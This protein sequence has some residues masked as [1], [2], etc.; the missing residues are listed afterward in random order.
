MKF[1]HTNIENIQI[2]KV[3][4]DI[5][6]IHQVNT[7]SRFS[8]SDGLL[9]LPKDGRNTNVI[10]IDINIE[11]KYVEIIN[12]QYGPVSDYV[13]THGHMDHIAHVYAWEQVGAKIHAPYP[14]SNCLTDLKHFYESFEMQVLNDFSLIEQFA[15][16]NKYQP[17]KQ[18]ISFYPSDTLTFKNILM[19]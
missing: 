3:T 4:D 1:N 18:V 14:E 5:L 9:I 8:C 13:N 16:L 7:F 15:A 2:N 17:C 6:L 10:A 12:E 19:P 11:S